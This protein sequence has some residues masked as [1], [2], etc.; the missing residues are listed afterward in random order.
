MTEQEELG[1][2]INEM[3]VDH[4]QHRLDRDAGLISNAEMQVLLGD[5]RR[6]LELLRKR[7]RESSESR[8]REE[9]Q[10]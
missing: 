10:E 1:L 2:L 9:V 7:L 3:M 6:R 5:D 4:E 8:R